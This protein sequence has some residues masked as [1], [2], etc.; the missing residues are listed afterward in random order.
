MEASN[1]QMLT[2]VGIFGQSAL[3]MQCTHDESSDTIADPYCFS[4]AKAVNVDNFFC[5]K[6]F[7]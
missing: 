4:M 6:P 2:S 1:S 5:A 3:E 7:L